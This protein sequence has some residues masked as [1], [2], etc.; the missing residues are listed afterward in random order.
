MHGARKASHPINL[1]LVAGLAGLAGLA[2]GVTIGVAQA[3]P[4]ATAPAATAAFPAG[5]TTAWQNGSFSVDTPNVV[6]RADIVLGKPNTAPSQFVPLGNGTLGAAVWAANGFTAQLNRSDTFPDRK[7]PGQVL[8][9]GL[10]R[11]TGASDFTGY[12]DPYDGMLHESGGGMTL[13]AYVRADTAQL[14]VDVTGAD[15]NSTQTAQVKLWSGRSPSALSSGATAVLAET[16]PDNSGLG[17]SGQTFGSLAG[18]SAGGRNVSASNPDSLTAQVSFNPNTDGT[19]RVIVAAPSWTGGDALSTANSVINGDTTKP[20]ST[21]DA[22]HL[23]WWHNYWSTAGLIK[24]TSSDGSGEYIEN[25]RTLYL[26]DA[27]AERGGSSPG[28]QAGVADLFNFSQDHQ[29]WFPAGFWFWNLRMQVQANLSA[30]EESLNTPVFN[31]YQSNISNISSW[32]SAKMPGRQ[33]LCVPETMRFNGN[34]YYFG[35]ESNASCDSTIAPSYNAQTLTSGAEIGLW[36]WQTYLA[37]DDRSFLSANYPLMSGA[38]R[39]LLSAATT[40]SDGNLH[41][42]ANAHET[43]W[44]VTDPVTDIVAMQALFPATVQ[45]AQTLGVDGSLVSQLNAAIGKIP[46]LPRTDTATQ[47]QVLTPSADA[48]GADMIALSTQPT[49]TRHNSENLGLEAVWPYN[50]IG[51][52]SSLTALAKR[53]YSSRS[54]VNANDWNFDSLQAA[55]LGLASEVQNDL[56]AATKSYQAYPSGL[57]GFGGNVGDEPYIEQSGV[58]AAA[59]SEALAQDYDGLLRITPAW[60]GSWTGAGTVYIQHNTKVDVQVSNGTPSTVAIVSG[61]SNPISMRSPWPG[62]AVTVVDGSSGAT[63]VGSQ[64]NATFSIPVQAGH[65]YLVELTSSPTTSL[66][67]ASISGSPATSAKHLGN[68]SIGLDSAGTAP[69]VSFRAHANGMYVTAENAGAS[70][71]IANRTAIGTWEEFDMINEGNGNI[72]LR[73]HANNEYVCADNAG[74]SPL[75][76]NRTAVGLWETFALIH[77]SDGSISL[78]AKVN[79]DYVTAENAGN[80]ALIANRT[81]IGPWEEF[82]LIND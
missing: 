52:S 75:I 54:Y 81:A 23:A 69:V 46:P 56:L 73:A 35:G 26:Y 48:Q 50:L 65:S 62:Q 45:A 10:S 58:A 43:Q 47:S 28:S 1:L 29:D 13:T 40:G 27:A 3:A 36:V 49:A 72:A 32:T 57:A 38:A 5:T 66:P 41:T 21:I 19:F 39:F 22:A 76:A 30:G 24:I 79:N 70:P 18:V 34:G 16:W 14:V 25:L 8:I 71:L 15:P 7:S 17:A 20:A 59:V 61:T 67:F 63:V 51:D 6:R 11:L 78:Q 82:D 2:T 80:S 42:Q 77:N 64:S 31:L 33:G 37:T 68:V 74:A 60:P 44:N 55:R 53:T 9:P 4:A 12:L